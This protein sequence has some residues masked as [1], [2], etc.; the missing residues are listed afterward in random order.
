M[1]CF[2]AQVSAIELVTRHIPHAH[3]VP[4]AALLNCMLNVCFEVT[5]VHC[6]QG[7]HSEWV[8]DVHNELTL[9]LQDRCS[10][11]LCVVCTCYWKAS[12]CC[13]RMRRSSS[14]LL[15]LWCFVDVLCYFLGGLAHCGCFFG[16]ALASSAALVLYCISAATCLTIFTVL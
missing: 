14:R 15:L 16:C 6:P 1:S 13:R 10:G 9:C 5:R 7:L 12:C 8:S 11:T 4:V 3:N 2:D